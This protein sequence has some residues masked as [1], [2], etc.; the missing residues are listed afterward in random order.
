M[1]AEGG[2]E[3]RVDVDLAGRLIADQV[4]EYASVELGR[5]Y[6]ADDHVAV[7]LGD[8]LGVWLPATQFTSDSVTGA[9]QLAKLQSRRWTFPASVQVA[10]GEPTDYYPFQWQILNWY[11][12]STA[13]IVPL[14]SA[15]CA[16][17]GH[18]LR[19]IHRRAPADA[20]PHGGGTST[21][22][23]FNAEMKALL[24][25]SRTMT[26]PAGERLNHDTVG[27]YWEAGLEAEI[28]SP[29]TWIHG[30]LNPFAVLSDHGHFAG[31]CNWQF[32]GAGDPA[33]DLGAVTSL[34]PLTDKIAAWDAYGPFSKALRAR[35]DAYCKLAMLRGVTSPSPFLANGAWDTIGHDE[36]LLL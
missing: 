29:P 2:D 14:T 34:L 31:L 36:D 13:A 15:A 12:M 20:P 27:R 25:Q 26:G 10:A 23:D 16:P 24:D 1:A 6:I 11:G 7:R 22:A 17:I 5:R 4:P 8:E 3:L 33:V 18:A 32:F 21:L 9:A 30:G 35:S 19:E 28:D